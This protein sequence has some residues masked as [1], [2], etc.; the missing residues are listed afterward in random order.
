M[1]Y[2]IDF[3]FALLGAFISAYLAIL[4]QNSKK[5]NIRIDVNEASDSP[6]GGHRFLHVKVSNNFRTGYVSRFIKGNVS[7]LYCRAQLE[8]MDVDTGSQLF[9]LTGRWASTPEP[10][11]PTL[12]PGKILFDPSKAMI[13]EIENIMPGE[14]K[15][16]DVAVKFKG[17]KHFTGFNNW[18]Y[19]Y[20][21]W[22][23]PDWSTNQTKVRL[24]VHVTCDS[25]RVTKDFMLINPNS[26]I[27]NF[28]ITTDGAK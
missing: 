8:F 5:P 12:T 2:L 3:I 28:R 21:K 6:D 9:S 7:A 14:S 18:S 22:Q 13:G 15:P 23:N 26:S 1:S 27:S 25:V 11:L 4:Q 24:R 16:L 10:G 20:Q 19:M 17:E